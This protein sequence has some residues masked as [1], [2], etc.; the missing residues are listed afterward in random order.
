MVGKPTHHHQQL[1]MMISGI[2]I[3]HPTT[4]LTRRDVILTA[5]TPITMITR[6]QLIQ[7]KRLHPMKVRASPMQHS[8]MMANMEQCLLSKK[9]SVQTRVIQK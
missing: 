9:Q 3:L 2:L 6:L 7:R 4:I 1:L 8:M 5:Q